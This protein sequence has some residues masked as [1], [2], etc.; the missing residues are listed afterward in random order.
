MVYGNFKDFRRSA[1]SD[2]ILRD[3]AFIIAKNQKYDLIQW[4]INLPQWSI[5]RLQFVLLRL[6]VKLCQAK[7]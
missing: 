1:A 6:Q 4:L 3:R 5:K 2:K 7:K